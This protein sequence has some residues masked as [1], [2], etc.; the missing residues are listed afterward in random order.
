MAKEL[1][2]AVRGPEAAKELERAKKEKRDANSLKIYAQDQR[3]EIDGTAAGVAEDV[4]AS[5]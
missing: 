1:G 4:R 3:R 5:T 2:Q